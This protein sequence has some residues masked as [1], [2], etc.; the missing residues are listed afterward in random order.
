MAETMML[1][2]TSCASTDLRDARRWRC[3]TLVLCG[4]CLADRQIVEAVRARA[5]AETD[6]RL[7]FAVQDAPRSWPDRRA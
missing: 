7:V 2:C 3:T 1:S 4:R 5:R 6:V